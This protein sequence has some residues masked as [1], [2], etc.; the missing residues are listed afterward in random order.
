MRYMHY[1]TL[2]NAVESDI[3]FVYFA[4]RPSFRQGNQCNN[5]PRTGLA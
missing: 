5:R 2:A 4:D 1:F 3:V